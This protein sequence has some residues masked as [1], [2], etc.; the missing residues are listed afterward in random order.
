MLKQSNTFS[1]I[2]LIYYN[3]LNTKHTKFH[4]KDFYVIFRVF[5]V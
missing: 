4:E 2:P 1:K 5:R 3:F